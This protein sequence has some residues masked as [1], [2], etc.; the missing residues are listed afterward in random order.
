MWAALK[1]GEVRALVLDGTVLNYAAATECSFSVLDGAFEQFDQAA[2]FP[3]GFNNT[4]LLD[5]YNEA[6][7]ALQRTGVTQDIG[8]ATLLPDAEECEAVGETS[9]GITLRQVSGLWILL[10]GA[11]AMAVLLILGQQI[12]VRYMHQK[13]LASKM[14]RRTS[15]TI[16]GLTKAPSARMAQRLQPPAI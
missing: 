10:A 7:A 9:T 6:L 13:L 14:G 5:D 11:V 12:Y 4:K 16:N 1:A 8:D 15:A 2:A 3:V